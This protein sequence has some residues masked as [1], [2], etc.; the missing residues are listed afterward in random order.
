MKRTFALLATMAATTAPAQAAK[1]G[2]SL[3]QR[4]RLDYI[5]TYIEE[6]AVKERLEPALLRALIRVESN[7]NHKATSRVGAKG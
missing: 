3:I 7:F 1:H 4:I 2:P 6:A 5:E